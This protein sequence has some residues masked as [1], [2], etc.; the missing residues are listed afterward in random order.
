M[1]M[2]LPII[3]IIGIL[4]I[5]AVVIAI[6]IGLR[7]VLKELKGDKNTNYKAS[8]GWLVITILSVV[9]MALSWLFNMGWYRVILIW[10]PLPLIHTIFF[11]V[12]NIRAS[13]KVLAF[14][15]LKK[16]IIL[17]CITFLLGYLIFPDGGDVG[18][19]YLFFSLIRNDTVA[20][21]MMYVAPIIFIA[22]IVILVLEYV[23]L[24]KK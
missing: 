20:N 2:S 1:G 17:S 14:P 12:I 22:N 3:P 23:E 19:M 7:Y 16:Y 4:V 13:G 11:L 18:G 8:K 24:S 15:K 10:I 21:I 9:V 5:S 6:V